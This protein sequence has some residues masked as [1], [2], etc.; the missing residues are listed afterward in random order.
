[1]MPFYASNLCSIAYKNGDSRMTA[2]AILE[3]K[4]FLKLTF[5]QYIT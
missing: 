3:L 5:N 4:I 2:A 1:M